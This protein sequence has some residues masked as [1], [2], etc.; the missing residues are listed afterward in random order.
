M[1]PFS[2]VD[3][4]YGGMNPSRTKGIAFTDLMC[5]IELRR[6][7]QTFRLRHERGNKCNVAGYVS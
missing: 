2:I 3:E 1:R 4:G 7:R 5:E 6:K